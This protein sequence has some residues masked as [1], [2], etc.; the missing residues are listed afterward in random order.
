MEARVFG[1]GMP[2][3][4]VGDVRPLPPLAEQ[5]RIVDLLAA[6]HARFADLVD[7]HA[8]STRL[9]DQLALH[10]VERGLYAQLQS[11]AEPI[12]YIPLILDADL[13]DTAK[14]VIERLQGGNGAATRG[15]LF[16]PLAATLVKATVCGAGRRREVE[17]R[18]LGSARR[19]RACVAACIGFLSRCK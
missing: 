15:V 12:E 10:S 11:I 16:G 6:A 3:I 1:L 4:N 17:R 8:S 9:I 5:D 19:S 14:H 18:G 13:H 7:D 2:R